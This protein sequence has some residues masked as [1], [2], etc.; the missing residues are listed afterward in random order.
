MA[1]LNNSMKGSA[2]LALRL[3][4]LRLEPQQGVI[5]RG[6]VSLNSDDWLVWVDVGYTVGER[7]IFQQE[8]LI[9]N[10]DLLLFCDKVEK[11]IR[12][13]A[14]G[15]EEEPEGQQRHVFMNKRS[16]ELDLRVHKHIFHPIGLIP[17]VEEILP[18]IQYFMHVMVETNVAAGELCSG[19]SG[20]ALII[21]PDEEVLLAFVHDLR[22]ETQMTL[23]LG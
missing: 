20:P 10:Q 15:T 4:L 9:Y 16:P 11:M 6:R 5:R 14:A 17:R 22:S 19:G 7:V 2:T 23:L 21:R 1:E 18:Q 8:V 3:D 12:G 13:T